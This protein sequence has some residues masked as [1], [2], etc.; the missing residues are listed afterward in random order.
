[1]GVPPG[2]QQKRAGEEADGAGVVPAL[3]MAALTGSLVDG[4][5]SAAA[6]EMPKN[7]EPSRFRAATRHSADGRRTAM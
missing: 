5:M 6:A 4:S 2:D 3:A 1:M 7:T